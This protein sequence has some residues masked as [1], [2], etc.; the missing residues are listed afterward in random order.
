M[1]MTN[2]RIEALEDTIAELTAENKRMKDHIAV[3]QPH[4]DPRRTAYV[5]NLHK[6]NERL[7][8]EVKRL[9]AALRMMAAEGEG[10][11]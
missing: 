2:T 11:R 10:R 5:E 8:A 3:W 1:I 9:D 4:E 6:E 7:K